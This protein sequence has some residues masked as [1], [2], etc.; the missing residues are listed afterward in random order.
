MQPDNF[1]E[2]FEVKHNIWYVYIV[3]ANQKITLNSPPNIL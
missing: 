1:G 3:N 2:V